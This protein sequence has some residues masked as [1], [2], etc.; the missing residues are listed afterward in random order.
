[1]QV[2]GKVLDFSTTRK[3]VCNAVLR[4]L[5]ANVTGFTMGAVFTLRLFAAPVLHEQ[6]DEL[7][8]AKA[9]D[10]PF[11]ETADDAS[12]LRRV[13]LDLTGNIPAPGKVNTFLEDPS[14]DKRTDRIDKLISSNDFAV[15]WADRLTVMLLERQ[16]Q[17]TVPNEQWRHFLESS[18]REKPLW[19]LMVRHMIEAKGH[20][21]A[22]PAMKFLGTANHHTMT[23]NI[24]RLFLGMD[25]TC[26][27]C[28][29]HP[30][31]EAWKQSDYWGLF[32]YLNQT[33]Q[34]TH[35]AENQ[36]YLVEDLA[37]TKVEFES[38]FNP[39]QK[40]TGPRLPHGKEVEIPAF[41][42]GDQ[43]EKPAEDGLP[44]VPRFHPRELL[45]RDLTAADNSLFARNSVN[46]MWFLLMGQGLFHPLDE[47]HDHNPPS[48]PQLLNLL[49]HEFV[50]HAFDLKWLLREIMLS[51]TYQRDS[52]LPEGISQVDHTRYQVSSPKNLT[53]EQLLR[54]VLRATGNTR[55]ATA[56]QAE[57]E[58][59][60]EAKKFDRKGYF[61][62][63]NTD[64][65]PSLDEIKSIFAMT[66]GQSPG[67][68]EVDFT[69]GLNK[70][71]FLMNDR[72]IQHWLQPRE[73][74]LIDRLQKTAE[75]KEVARKLYLSVLSR[76]PEAEE[77][78]A[79][80]DYLQQNESRQ[81]DALGD[82]AWALLNSAEFRFNH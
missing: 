13:T 17:G 55:Y 3:R 16:D 73:G 49:G 41:E 76:L 30:S 57:H 25:L 34:A 4:S 7:V 36:V 77:Q 15:H 1:M 33:R 26:A 62:G 58:A 78:L 35:K 60:A 68:A 79:V 12:F 74:N 66:F 38:V 24:A 50:A 47:M 53:P 63:N 69:P 39:G 6:I 67:E 11:A 75:A 10:V 72:L 44:A 9:G 61:T 81:T 59:N 71:L 82:L 43:Y 29:D 19:D 70:A 23:E 64:L 32:A 22:R 8:R 20:G 54:A 21:P 28:H 2:I 45:A 51:E 80:A 56:L 27:R 37:T 31:V 5:L 48:H 14:S 18:L 52:R 40:T 42:E 46:R 65:P